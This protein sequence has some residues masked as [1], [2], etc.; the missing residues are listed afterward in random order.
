MAT[1]PVY[2]P[3]PGLLLALLL[4]VVLMTTPVP[5][6]LFNKL[7]LVML[8]FVVLLVFVLMSTPPLLIPFSGLIS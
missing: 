1:P 4:S 2:V 7:V 6:L 3:A 8:V 5:V